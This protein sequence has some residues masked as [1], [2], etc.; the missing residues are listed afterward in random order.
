MFGCLGGA[1]STSLGS[2]SCLSLDQLLSF[3]FLVSSMSQQPKRPLSA[4]PPPEQGRSSRP[5]AKKPLPGSAF[6]PVVLS[7]QL[8][9]NANKATSFE[10]RPPAG[11][12]QQK[13][14]PYFV[15]LESSDPQHYVDLHRSVLAVGQ[16]PDA[17]RSYDMVSQHMQ[18]NYRDAHQMFLTSRSPAA[19][20]GKLEDR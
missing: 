10:L 15:P 6:V 12:Q 16:L 7:A 14:T 18:Q 20:N 13:R 9:D 17:G 11:S 4:S 2:L 5:P 8:I 3:S 19:P 1:S